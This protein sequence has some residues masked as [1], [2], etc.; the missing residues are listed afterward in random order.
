MAS[1]HFCGGGLEIVGRVMKK[2]VC[3]SCGRDLHCCVQCRFH[4]PGYHNQCREPKAE[5]VHDRDR[6]NFCDYFEFMGAAA[7]GAP[8][9]RDQARRTLDDLFKKG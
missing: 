9:D 2:D 4:D 1:C 6:V 8:S 7:D 3:P 5:M